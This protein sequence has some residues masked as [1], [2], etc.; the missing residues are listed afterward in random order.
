MSIGAVTGAVVD[1]L[2]PRRCMLCGARAKGES[3]CPSCAL[4]LPDLPDSCCPRC[5]LPGAGGR[6][7]GVCLK[8]PPRFDTTTALYAYAF[9]A[10]R[11][12]HSLKYGRRLASADFLATRLATRAIASGHPAPDRIVPVPLS[13]RRLAERGFNQAMEIAR[14]LAARLGGIVDT[15][16]VERVQDT[17]PLAALPFAARRRRIRHAFECRADLGGQC[18]WVIDDVM[19]T[20]AT[21]NEVATVLKRHGAAQVHN[22]VVARTLRE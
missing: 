6:P 8:H 11:L 10:D 3:V 21:L 4:E 19:T 17:P 5:A 9:P 7:C 1:A 2:L 13:R 18:I 20:G 22:F 14:T 12:I 15:A 16:A